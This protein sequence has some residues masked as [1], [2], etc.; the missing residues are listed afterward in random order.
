MKENTIHH[1]DFLENTLP[2]K[3]A[4]LII[5]DPPYFEIKGPFDYIWP[6]FQ[7]Y[8]KDVRTW[9]QECQRLLADSGTLFW[10]GHAKKIAYS[11]LILDEHFTLIS[12]LVWEKAECQTLRSEVAQMRTFAPITERLLMYDKGPSVA[13]LARIDD[14]PAHFMPVKRYLDLW[15]ASS[16]LTYKEVVAQLG[17]ISSHFFGFT[18]K[19]KVQF[20]FPT[21]EKWDLMGK[22]YPHHLDHDTLRALYD[23]EREAHKALVRPFTLQR[24]TADVLRFSQEAHL[25]KNHD[26]PTQKPEQ[27]T[28][29]LIQ[30]TTRPGD[31][32]LVPF[33][34]SGTE[35]AMAAREG[36]P[37][38]GFDINKDYIL[39][40]N[41][42]AQTH[43]AA[44]F[45][46]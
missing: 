11:Q 4:Q 29:L 7:A 14:D 13:G 8:L 5:A 33:A 19:D 10:Y 28:R 20:H 2:D 35:C 3:C 45:L 21:R 23:T 38:Q 15:L 22:I 1:M 31:L 9:A 12:S 18:R 32:V 39:P 24:M 25:T 30:S 41:Q 34:G 17:S 26:H 37:F 40:A 36:R 42:R 43:L 46:F 16:G 6:D 44:P 27:L